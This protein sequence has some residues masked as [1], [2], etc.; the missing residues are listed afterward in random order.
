M[1]S[2]HPATGARSRREQAAQG[3]GEHAVAGVDALLGA[4]DR[5][6]RRAM[7]AQLVT[8]LNV[9][10]DQREVVDQ[11]DSDGGRQRPGGLAPE[12]L[13]G[14]ERQRWT[15]ALSGRLVRWAPLR[16]RPAEMVCGPLAEPPPGMW[17]G[18]SEPGVE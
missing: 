14:P 18:L 11:L 17:S 2:A 8:V 7:A 6:H 4:P 13:A 15:D 9:V 12:R 16:V 1:G 5:P 10:V 3:V